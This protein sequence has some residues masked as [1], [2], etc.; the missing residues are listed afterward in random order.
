MD[1]NEDKFSFKDIGVKVGI[2]YFVLSLS[3]IGSI[4]F[5]LYINYNY[6]PI[7]VGF[8]FENI[9][10]TFVSLFI[11]FSIL[12]ILLGIAIIVMI[13]SLPLLIIAIFL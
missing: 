8:D 4:L 10:T 6:I 11:I 7:N 5:Y 2:Y 3:F 1:T 9:L 13:S 12:F